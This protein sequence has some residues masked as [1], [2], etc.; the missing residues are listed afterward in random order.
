MSYVVDR[1]GIYYDSFGPSEFERLALRR[2]LDPAAAR[3]VAAPAIAALREIGLSK[4]NAFS[5]APELLSMLDVEREGNVLVVDQTRGDAAVSGAG[6]DAGRFVEM[7]LAALQDNP[8]RRIRDPG[9]S[10][11]RSPGPQRLS[12]RRRPARRPERRGARWT[13]RRIAS[14]VAR[15]PPLRGPCCR[16]SVASTPSPVSWGSRR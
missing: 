9:P 10:W 11:R 4:Y 1:L 13:P 15:R 2:A 7:L 3:R 6:A 12:E 5:E 16:G 14:S 8:G